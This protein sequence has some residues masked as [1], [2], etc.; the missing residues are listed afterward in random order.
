VAGKAAA[1]P[2][3]PVIDAYRRRLSMA[4]F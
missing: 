3:D 4:I 2:S 1:A